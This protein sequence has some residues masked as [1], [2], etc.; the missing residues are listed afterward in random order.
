[1]KLIDIQVGQV[2]EDADPRSR[3]RYLVVEAVEEGYV[4]CQVLKTG[5]KT[6]IC[7]NRFKPSSTGY[8]LLLRPEM[9]AKHSLTEQRAVKPT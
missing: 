5:K 9:V 8:R 4:G 1:M 2:W 7:R 3:G 6:R